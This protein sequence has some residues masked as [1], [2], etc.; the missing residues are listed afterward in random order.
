MHDI[1]QGDRLMPIEICCR[2]CGQP[3]TPTAE[4][5]RRGPPHWWHCPACR[6]A[7]ARDS[8]VPA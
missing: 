7:A 2:S 1:A 4:D 6:A 5:L 3:F 8:E